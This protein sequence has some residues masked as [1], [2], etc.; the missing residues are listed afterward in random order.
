MAKFLLSLMTGRFP[1]DV[2]S[3]P[4]TRSAAVVAWPTATHRATR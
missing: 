4:A 1:Y 3:L 2:R